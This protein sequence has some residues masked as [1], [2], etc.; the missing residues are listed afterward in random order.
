MPDE[1]NKK[2]FINPNLDNGREH[3]VGADL[4]DWDLNDTYDINRVVPDVKTFI[5]QLY[6]HSL[7]SQGVLCDISRI[8]GTMSK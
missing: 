1:N 2:E 4:Y 6:T 7:Y 8:Y 5:D 3:R